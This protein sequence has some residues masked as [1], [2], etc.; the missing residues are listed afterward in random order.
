MTPE[1][2]NTVLTALL[3]ALAAVIGTA[4]IAAFIFNARLATLDERTIHLQDDFKRLDD[5]FKKLDQLAN[6]TELVANTSQQLAASANASIEGLRREQVAL[7]QAVQKVE[8][9]PN[10]VATRFDDLQMYLKSRFDE[11]DGR[12][13][14]LGPRRGEP[15]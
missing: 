13:N 4:T 12:I 3:S 9:L 1:T 8:S 5:D 14:E 11:I 2:R 10:S 6:T 15:R 7:D